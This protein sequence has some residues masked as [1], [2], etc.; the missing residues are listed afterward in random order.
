MSRTIVFCLSF[1]VLV[2]NQAGECLR[3]ASNELI[4][5][6]QCANKREDSSSLT[7]QFSRPDIVLAIGFN[8]VVR[9]FVKY[10]GLRCFDLIRD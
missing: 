7:R 3:N 4:L 6:L 9:A 8:R 1:S 2:L 5:L 10:S